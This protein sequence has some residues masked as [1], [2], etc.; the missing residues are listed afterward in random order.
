VGILGANGS[1]KSTL[2]KVIQ[3][4]LDACA[5]ECWINRSMRWSRFAQHHVDDLALHLT[6]AECLQKTYPEVNELEARS[7]LARF[8]LSGDLATVP[9]RCLSG[10]QKSRVALAMAA[11]KKPHLILLDEPTNHLDMD[12]IDSLIDALKEYKGAVLLVSHDQYFLQ[13]VATSY[14]SLSGGFVR[15]FQSLEEAKKA[16]YSQLGKV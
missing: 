7:Q 16:T 14:W 3:G 6:A 5:G 13:Q 1:G 12:T 9:S 2:L 11:M 15:N 8:G 4:E 10:G